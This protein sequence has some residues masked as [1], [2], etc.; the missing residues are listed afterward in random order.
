MRIPRASSDRSINAVLML[1]PQEDPQLGHPSRPHCLTLPAENPAKH[2]ADTAA[3]GTVHA[4]FHLAQLLGTDLVR[5][6]RFLLDH[7]GH[8]RQ[9]RVGLRLEL[10]ALVLVL[11]EDDL[12]GRVVESAVRVAAVHVRV[13]HLGERRRRA[14]AA[15]AARRVGRQRRRVG[16]RAAEAGHRVGAGAARRRARPRVVAA[17]AARAGAGGGGAVRRRGVGA[18]RARVQLL[19]LALLLAARGVLGLFARKALDAA[20]GALVLGDD[21]FAQRREEDVE[22]AVEVV[23]GDA[24][25]PLEQHEELLLHQVDLGL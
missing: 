21:L 5:Q 22:L 11:R 3:F 12:H 8:L 13:R 17:V 23:L 18:V 4:G 15:A 1:S 2:A 20:Q 16:V 7:L 14:R 19:E 9:L 25:L 24:Q 10:A 6:Q